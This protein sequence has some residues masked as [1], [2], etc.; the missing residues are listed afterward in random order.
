MSDVAL[1]NCR[2]EKVL[3]FNS[4]EKYTLKKILRSA[5][6]RHAIADCTVTNQHSGHIPYVT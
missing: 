5:I 1:S 3:I 2:K 4:G 6:A